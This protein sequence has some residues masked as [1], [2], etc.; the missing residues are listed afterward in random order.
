MSIGCMAKSYTR[1]PRRA[2][3][4]RECEVGLVALRQVAR[5]AGARRVRRPASLRANWARWEIQFRPSGVLV[6]ARPT[7]PE[8]LRLPP[9]DTS[10]LS[11]KAKSA[12]L[13]RRLLLLAA[14]WTIQ[15]WPRQKVRISCI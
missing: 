15:L 8:W 12:P 4:G 10:K 6:A 1:R 11:A 7:P 14:E 3:H 13:P 5:R 9:S 2:M